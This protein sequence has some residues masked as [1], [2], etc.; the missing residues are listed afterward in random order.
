M[1]EGKE[2]SAFRTAALIWGVAAMLWTFLFSI[3][4]FAVKAGFYPAHFNILRQSNDILELIEKLFILTLFIYFI[5]II[6]AFL[7]WWTI[8][9]QYKKEITHSEK[10]RNTLFLIDMIGFLF[11]ISIFGILYIPHEGGGKWG[12]RSIQSILEDFAIPLSF[13][14]GFRGATY[15]FIRNYYKGSPQGIRENT[16]LDYF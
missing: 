6:P 4:F 3:L 10:R 11:F 8:G 14:I 5:S 1:N 13:W 7:L 16:P 15:F 9:R 2:R 12:D